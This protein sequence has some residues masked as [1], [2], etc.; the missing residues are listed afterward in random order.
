MVIAYNMG[1]IKGHVGF[2][3]GQEMERYRDYEASP[4]FNENWFRVFW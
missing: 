1:V 4:E 3:V 2:F